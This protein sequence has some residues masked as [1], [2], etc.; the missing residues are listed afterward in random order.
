MLK[1]DEEYLDWIESKYSGL[2]EHILEIE[3]REFPL[4]P[5]CDSNRTAQVLTGMV[6][7]TMYL[8]A[9]TDKVKLIPNNPDRVSFYCNQCDQY[10]R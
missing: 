1:V 7:R 5:N 2:K 6:G 3:Q 8:S 10:F 4:C 9:A